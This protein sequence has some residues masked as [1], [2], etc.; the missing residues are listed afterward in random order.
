MSEFTYRSKSA[1]SA[2]SFF[3]WSSATSRSVMGSTRVTATPSDPAAFRMA[4][5]FC[6]YWSSGPGT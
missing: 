1:T 3:C 4:S 2:W 6:M 5:R